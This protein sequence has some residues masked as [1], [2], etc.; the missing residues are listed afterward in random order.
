VLGRVIVLIAAIVGIGVAGGRAGAAG[1]RRSILALCR[2]IVRDRAAGGGVVEILPGRIE[3]VAVLLIGA[4]SLPARG[5]E[6][7]QI[8]RIDNV[9][10]IEVV[11]VK[12]AGDASLLIE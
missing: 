12:R 9:A 10:R 7:A 3:R 6:S 2:D 5:E 8:G 1:E 11:V 4:P